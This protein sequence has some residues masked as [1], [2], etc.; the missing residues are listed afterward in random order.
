LVPESVPPLLLK[1]TLLLAKAAIGK[2][3][4]NTANNTIRLMD[5]LLDHLNLS[6][7]NSANRTR[8][9]PETTVL[10]NVHVDFQS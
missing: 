6:L 1:S 4:A 5:F 3:R 7:Y 8:Q 9:N 2:A 10:R